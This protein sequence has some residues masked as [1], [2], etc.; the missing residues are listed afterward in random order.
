M[1]FHY[2]GENTEESK[3]KL[4]ADHID[5]YNK[6]SSFRGF[7][8]VIKV[9]ESF[10]FTHNGQ[11]IGYIHLMEKLHSTVKDLI[12][13]KKIFTQNDVLDFLNQMDKIL[14]QS[15]HVI[16]TPLV[17][18]DIKPSNIGIRKNLQGRMEYVLLD[19]E[20]SVPIK[21][22]IST[23]GSA[24]ITNFANLKGITLAYAP[25]EQ[26]SA[27]LNKTGQITTRVDV[28]AV[29][30]IAAEMLTGV[31]PNK[32]EGTGFYY[33]SLTDLPYIWKEIIYSLCHEDYMQRPSRI[34]D[35]TNGNKIPRAEN[36]ISF[37]KEDKKLY[38]Y[39]LIGIGLI[40]VSIVT[41][42]GTYVYSLLY[43]HTIDDNGGSISEQYSKNAFKI[44]NLENLRINRTI[45]NSPYSAI[46]DA[47]V[48]L[49]NE[50]SESGICWGYTSS[51][52][53]I[54]DCSNPLIKGSGSFRHELLNLSELTSYYT[55]VYNRSSDGIRYGAHAKFT[56]LEREQ[57]A[58]EQSP[59]FGTIQPNTTLSPAD[60]L[61]ITQP[62]NTQTQ[63]P[64]TRAM[65]ASNRLVS[66][67]DVEPIIIN[68]YY[69]N[70]PL[71]A[72]NARVF[73]YITVRML[74]GTSGNVEM[75]E[76]DKIL[77]YDYQTNNYVEVNSIGYG[78]IDLIVI[79][80]RRWKFKPAEHQ[81]YIVR[82]WSSQVFNF[83]S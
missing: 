12:Q 35:V 70:T 51:I 49:V 52:T 39:L 76:I 22:K 16:E 2:F 21:S 8:G 56:T 47:N 24:R 83:G 63:T 59:S 3:N 43:Q 79:A 19:F 15:H 73:A 28:Y 5:E 23:N 62:R 20:V 67:P 72:I 75:V 32:N 36:R 53:N 41:L 7:E 65:P 11:T 34:S 29:G 69:P 14:Y 57:L 46:I 1:K 42:L 64:Q 54:I 78:I 44:T 66:N 38:R 18:S 58:F 55:W 77:A 13:Q 25:P 9:F 80:S 45:L 37:L 4:I 68:S 30:A 40:S 31:A 61:L 17:H 74:I 81:G 60:T 71:E 6:I 10:A 27:Y 26:I 48:S 33:V 82:S 50:Q